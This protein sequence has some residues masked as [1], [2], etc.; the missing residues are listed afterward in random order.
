MEMEI[1]SRG[2]REHYTADSAEAARAFLADKQ[3]EEGGYSLLV[4]TPE[5]NWGLDRDGLFLEGLLPF[6]LNILEMD[7][8]GAIDGIPS[9][10]S[11]GLAS[12]GLTDNY[13]VSVLCGKC[14]NRWLDGVR[15]RERTVVR[16][17]ACQ[18]LNL[19]E[20]A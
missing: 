5:G 17:P 9:L 18:T 11:L 12:K 4:H 19:V 20:S 13:V 10:F 8:H 16:C 1:S 7:C 3:V 6:Q 14:L 2:S 15:Y